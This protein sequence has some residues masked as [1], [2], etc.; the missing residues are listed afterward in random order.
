MKFFHFGSNF[1][2]AFIN[3][4]YS[5]GTV[6]Q[7]GYYNVTFKL[8]DS[9]L[10]FV[11]LRLNVLRVLYC[12]PFNGLRSSSS[13]DT[14]SAG[15]VIHIVL[16]IS[17]IQDSNVSADTSNFRVNW[18]ECVFDKWPQWLIPQ[19]LFRG[20]CC[21]GC[22]RLNSEQPLGKCGRGLFLHEYLFSTNQLHK[23]YTSFNMGNYDQ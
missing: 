4:E 21:C 23:Y 7:L 15:K 5:E 14:F 16:V 19:I 18:M 6:L 2:Q 13:F 17:T 22:C 20:C 8:W 10:G 3:G 1:G 12:L 9:V 11:I